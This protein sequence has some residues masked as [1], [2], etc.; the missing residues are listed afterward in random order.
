M[1]GAGAGEDAGDES[2]GPTDGEEGG[3]DVGTKAAPRA[4]ITGYLA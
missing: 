4:I 3:D 1:I 2:V